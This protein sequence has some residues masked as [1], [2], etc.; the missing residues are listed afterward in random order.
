MNKSIIGVA[1]L[2]GF[3]FSVPIHAQ[4]QSQH[5]DRST[6]QTAPSKSEASGQSGAGTNS[7]PVTENVRKSSP[8]SATGKSSTESEGPRATGAGPSVPRT[9]N[10]AATS[11]SNNNST[12]GQSNGSTNQ[13][14]EAR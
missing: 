13:G 6:S 3:A 5:S 2:C 10:G 11:G 1:W 8:G 7:A 14:G 12:S 4:N 9:G